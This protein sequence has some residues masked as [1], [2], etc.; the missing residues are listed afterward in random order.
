M[1]EITLKT[2]LTLETSVDATPSGASM[3]VSTVPTLTTGNSNSVQRVYSIYTP[4]NI[5]WIE[6]ETLM[7]TGSSSTNY[8][9]E[10]TIS[11]SVSRRGIRRPRGILYP[12]GTYQPYRRLFISRRIY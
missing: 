9:N 7:S 1:A 4:N 6:I 5:S 2:G 11:S 12:R 10:R 3:G 8:E